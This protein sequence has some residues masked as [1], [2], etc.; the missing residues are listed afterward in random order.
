MR[1]RNGLIDM[2]EPTMPGLLATSAPSPPVQFM[3]S[4]QVPRRSPSGVVTA[5]LL[6]AYSLV[7]GNPLST[8]ALFGATDFRHSYL[9]VVVMTFTKVSL[10]GSGRGGLGRNTMALLFWPGTEGPLVLRTLALRRE[11]TAHWVAQDVRTALMIVFGG[12]FVHLILRGRREAGFIGRSF[13]A[14][15]ALMIA[16]AI[17]AVLSNAVFI[18]AGGRS[19]YQSNIDGLITGA[20]LG[21]MFGLLVCWPLA[22]I[23]A[24]IARTDR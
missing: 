2:T 5:G 19:T 3:S 4:T 18:V 13:S 21:S 20:G 17:S 1:R 8:R 12:L 23:A 24:A 22:L 16:G 10:P 7:I 6:T 15:G 14:V 9:S 11:R